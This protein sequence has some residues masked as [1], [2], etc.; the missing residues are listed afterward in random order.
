M[1]PPAF[2]YQ[3]GHWEGSNITLTPVPRSQPEQGSTAFSNQ[4]PPWANEAMQKLAALSELKAGWDGHHGKPITNVA[5]SYTKNILGHIMQPGVPLPSITPLSYGGVQLEWHRKGW[6]IE[7]EVPGPGRLY[8]FA[9]N[10]QT[11]DEREL[12]LSADLSDLGAV[13]ENIKD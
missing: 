6:D 11:E 5:V 3:D 1:T 10:I 13:V 7:I 2:A 12:E 9:R 4:R 8:V